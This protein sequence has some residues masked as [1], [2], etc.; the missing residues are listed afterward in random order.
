MIVGLEEW[1]VWLCGAWP[2]VSIKGADPC[3]RP[4]ISFE[5]FAKY[6]RLEGWQPAATMPPEF[7]RF[8]WTVDRVE[9]KRLRSIEPD[10]LSAGGL[11]TLDS[12]D[13]F[14]EGTPEPA[15]GNWDAAFPAYP[16]ENDPWVFMHWLG[17]E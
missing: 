6:E 8:R 15:R 10:D 13:D 14:Y 5:Q 3:E 16:W 17:G 11:M 9:C 7:A 12:V 1:H 4:P 2:L